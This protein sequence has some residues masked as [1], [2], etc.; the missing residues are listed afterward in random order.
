MRFW[1]S[2]ILHW[3]VCF[4]KKACATSKTD[5]LGLGWTLLSCH[6]VEGPAGLILQSQIKE[7]CP[8][9]RLWGRQHSLILCLGHGGSGR[10]G[11][12][13]KMLCCSWV[14]SGTMWRCPTLWS[15]PD[16]RKLRFP[17]MKKWVLLGIF[18]LQGQT[19]SEILPG[20][21]ARSGEDKKSQ[22]N[23]WRGMGLWLIAHAVSYCSRRT[24][25]GFG[26]HAWPGTNPR[27]L[28]VP[29]TFVPPLPWLSLTSAQQFSSSS[30]TEGCWWKLRGKRGVLP[31]PAVPQVVPSRLHPCRIPNL[32]SGH[33]GEPAAVGKV[34]GEAGSFWYFLSEPC[35]TDKMLCGCFWQQRGFFAEVKAVHRDA[36]SPYQPS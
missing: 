27:F 18:S 25:A 19:H 10:E 4:Q 33:S 36:R 28:C 30:R 7:P 32:T 31:L 1:L 12:W 11:D 3:D 21:Q 5:V 9:Q 24:Q 20:L 8:A 13:P 14:F 26:T 29:H 34:R 2:L 23:V 16:F 22:I 35:L 15:T 17:R 6:G